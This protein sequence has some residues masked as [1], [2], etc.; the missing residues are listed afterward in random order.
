M[1]LDKQPTSYGRLASR[2]DLPESEV[3]KRADEALECV[4]A[5]VQRFDQAA[6]ALAEE[7]VKVWSEE[8]PGIDK[9]L[10]R[11][12]AASLIGETANVSVHLARKGG[13]R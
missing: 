3:F 10:F 5:A 8:V 2:L 7:I 6:Q 13:A 9:E 4:K 12:T 11:K 1:I